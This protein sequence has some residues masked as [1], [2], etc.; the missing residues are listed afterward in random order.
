MYNNVLLHIGRFKP[1]EI[2]ARTSK[3][4][5]VRVPREE[6]CERKKERRTGGEEKEETNV[7]VG[8]GRAFARKNLLSNR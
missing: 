8:K 4:R 5:K 7:E 2:Y 6:S 1:D 3:G